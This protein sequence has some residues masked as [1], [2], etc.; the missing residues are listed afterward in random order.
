MLVAFAGD[1]NE[2]GLLSEPHSVST[3]TFVTYNSGIFE[4]T[5]LSLANSILKAVLLLILFLS[6]LCH[7][8]I[9]LFL[10][11]I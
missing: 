7:D 6:G 9:L 4:L 10:K 2:M 5:S 8:T 11:F 3:L 1:V